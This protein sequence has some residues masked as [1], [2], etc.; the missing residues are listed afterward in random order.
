[1]HNNNNIASDTTTANQPQGYGTPFYRQY[2]LIALTVLYTLNFIDRILIQILAQPIIEEFQLQD[3]QFGL[4]SGLVF[5]TLY[6]LLG[7]PIARLAERYNRVRIIALSVIVWSVMTALCGFAGGFLS[8]LVF[9]VGVGIGEAGLTPAANSIIAD[10]F[11]PN[12]RARAMGT[13]AMGVTLGSVLAA[14]L[15]GPIADAFDWRTA[16]LVLGAPGVLIG[17]IF[18]VTT[19]EPPRGYTDPPGTEQR[20]SDNLRVTLGKLSDKPT[21][22]LNCAAATLVAF[23][24]YAL[25]A[26][27]V[28]Y[29]QRAFPV[30]LTE[31][32]L[33]V[34]VPAGLAASAGVFSGGYLTEKLS[35]RM[36]NAVVLIPGAGLIASVPFYVFAFVTPNFHLAIGS[37]MLGALLHYSYLGAQYTVCQGIADARSRATAV[38]IMLFVI[39]IIGYGLGPLFLGV[40]SDLFTASDIAASAH[41]TELTLQMCKGSAEALIATLGQ[42]KADACLAA[43]ASGLGLA[44][45]VTSLIFLVGGALYLCASRTLQRDLTGPTD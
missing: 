15:G 2:V 14:A 41:G 8:L 11:P 39:N 34:S 29:F 27:K 40:L 23:V 22:W 44:M 1:M 9:R 35:P 36:P 5:A 28:A 13:Y 16:F 7:I 19:R 26:F 25:T 32:A 45:V 43:N 4:L 18:W 21:F 20:G 33:T 31:V 38:A 24:G 42:A 6:T 3:W 30:S 12:S 37:V 10:Y 17:V